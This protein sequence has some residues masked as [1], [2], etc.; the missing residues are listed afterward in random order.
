[1]K[2]VPMDSFSTLILKILVMPL[3]TAWCC[4]GLSGRDFVYPCRILAQAGSND[5]KYLKYPCR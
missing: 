1:M 4:P 5:G 3:C 2:T